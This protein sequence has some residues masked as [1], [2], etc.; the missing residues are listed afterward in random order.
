MEGKTAMLRLAA[1]A[2]AAMIAAPA[3]EPAMAQ[4]APGPWTGVPEPNAPAAEA[5]PPAGPEAGETD[6]GT[7]AG[8]PPRFAGKVSRAAPSWRE[9][10]APADIEAYEAY[11]AARGDYD[12]VLPQS[13]YAPAPYGDAWNVPII[14]SPELRLPRRGIHRPARPL[15][16]AYRR[17]YRR[18]FADGS[19][20]RPRGEGRARPGGR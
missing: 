5:L 10:P 6:A 7:A 20:P 16:K 14:V 18:G 2:F 13:A 12:G 19:R 15:R 3:A 17:G 9:A 8:G 4:V 11:R 1:A